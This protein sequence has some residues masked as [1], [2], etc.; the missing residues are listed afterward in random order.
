MLLDPVG[1]AVATAPPDE[2]PV[3]EQDRLRFLSGRDWFRQGK[4]IPMDDVLAKFDLKTEDFP[5]SLEDTP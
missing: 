5:N 3:T 4:G 1:R 2:E